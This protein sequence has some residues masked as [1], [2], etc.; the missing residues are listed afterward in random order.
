ME[1]ALGL[2]TKFNVAVVVTVVQVISGKKIIIQ[3][4][5]TKLPSGWPHSQINPKFAFH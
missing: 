2:T 3:G 4:A 5:R 1:C